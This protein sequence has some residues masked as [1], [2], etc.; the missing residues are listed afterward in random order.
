M[1]V[2][3]V[4]DCLDDLQM[5]K[6]IINYYKNVEAYY[7][8]NVASFLN[9]D[10]ALMDV[11]FIGLSDING[12]KLAK[13]IRRKYVSKC[14]I[15]IS[16]HP[17]YVFESFKVHPFRFVRKH[18]IKEDMKLCM[19]ELHIHFMYKNTFFTY[20]LNDV[21]MFILSSS[22]IYIGKFKNFCYIY[23]T[24]NKLEKIPITLTKIIE[25]HIPDFYLVNKSTIINFNHI[26]KMKEN[27]IFVLDNGQEIEISRRKK[28]E[29]LLIYNQFR[30]R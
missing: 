10:F 8:Q 25:Q 3:V 12:I 24:G 2:V 15:F 19:E 20:V 21:E 5:M 6:K 27:C 26:I 16:W 22:I 14:I 13:Y 30:I 23:L 29:V 17:E 18:N 7:F 4:D 1:R 11:F 28:K 9:E